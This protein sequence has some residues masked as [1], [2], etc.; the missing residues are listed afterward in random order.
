VKSAHAGETAATAG[1]TYTTK[2]GTTAKKAAARNAG[3]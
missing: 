3:L 2:H 1:R